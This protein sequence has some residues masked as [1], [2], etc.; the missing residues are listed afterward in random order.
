[1]DLQRLVENIKCNEEKGVPQHTLTIMPKFNNSSIRE[2]T[3][4]FFLYGKNP[5]PLY[6]VNIE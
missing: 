2:P 6:K 5:Y 1:M 4:I 3:Y